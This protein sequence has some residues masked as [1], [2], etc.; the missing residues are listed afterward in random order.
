MLR[1]DMKVAVYELDDGVPE[2]PQYQA[3]VPQQFPTGV[4][5]PGSNETVVAKARTQ[6]PPPGAMVLSRR[7]S[8]PRPAPVVPPLAAAPVAYGSLCAYALRGHHAVEAPGLGGRRV[9]A[10]CCES[11]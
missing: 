2:F 11:R 5:H 9:L 7:H 4:E 6:T 3:G 10:C 1:F 8:A